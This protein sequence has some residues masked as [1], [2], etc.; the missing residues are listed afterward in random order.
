MNDPLPPDGAPAP[1][2]ATASTPQ[3]PLPAGG[4]ERDTLERLMFASLHEQR[5]ARRWRTFVR[6]AWLGFL[7]VCVC[8]G[9]SA[10]YELIEWAA[11]LML[12]QGADEFLGT[13][14][15]PWDTQSDMLFA[16][17]GGVA[18]QLSMARWQDAQMRRLDQM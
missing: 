14:G 9:F 12:G 15:D 8:L 17:L 7:V 3:A 4:W 6:L 2:P 18:A 5:Q 1:P 10:F 11:A 16:L 13:Q